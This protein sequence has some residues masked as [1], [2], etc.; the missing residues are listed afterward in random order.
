MRGIDDSNINC[1]L[2][3][4][5]KMNHECRHEISYISKLAQAISIKCW[6]NLKVNDKNLCTR[7]HVWDNHSSHTDSNTNEM[8]LHIF[9]ISDEL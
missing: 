5:V 1:K 9:Q 7:S 2:L 3:P 6:W 8:Y 4:K